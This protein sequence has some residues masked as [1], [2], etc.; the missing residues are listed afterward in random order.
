MLT[1]DILIPARDE[2]AA[3]PLVLGGPAARRGG[4]ASP[5]GGGGGQRLA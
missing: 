4:M 2:A 5:A 3:L 1:L